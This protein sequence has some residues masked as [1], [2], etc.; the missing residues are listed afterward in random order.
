M[1]IDPIDLI[2]QPAIPLGFAKL[3]GRNI[4][5]GDHPRIER[6]ETFLVDLPTIRPHK[7]SMTTMSGQTLMLVRIYSSDGIVGLGE[8]TT[9]GGLAYG[10]ESPESMKLAIDTYFTPHLL[11]GNSNRI[12]AA[13]GHHRQSGAQQSLRQMRDRDR[14]ARRPRQAHGIVGGGAHGRP[15]S[16]P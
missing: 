5:M 15:C 12:A 7:L 8:G 16:R 11:K 3:Y 10:A 9:I 4:G 2:R 14:A 13:D 6:V 1:K